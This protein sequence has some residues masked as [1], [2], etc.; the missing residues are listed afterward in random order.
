[1][2]DDDLFGSGEERQREP[3]ED[4]RRAETPDV[5][6]PNPFVGPLLFLVL[7]VAPV[8]ILIASNGDSVPVKWAGFSWEAPLWIVLAITF[9]A[10]AVVTRLF[11]WVW[12]AWRRRRKRLKEEAAAKRRQME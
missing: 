6:G 11:A 3:D 10:G 2:S 12:T 9:A 7:V 8:A 5:Q 4:R 1:M